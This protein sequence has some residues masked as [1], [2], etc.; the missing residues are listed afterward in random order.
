MVRVFVLIS[1]G[2]LRERR[3]TTGRTCR[4][5]GEIELNRTPMGVELNG[6]RHVL[7]AV[8]V[9]QKGCISLRSQSLL[10]IAPLSPRT[11]SFNRP[12]LSSSPRLLCH[13]A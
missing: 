6:S 10:G 12:A 2:H 4:R 8:H 1:L 9:A 11:T 13:Q 3:T 7:H 5:A